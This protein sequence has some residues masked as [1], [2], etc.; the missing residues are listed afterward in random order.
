MLIPCAPYSD[1]VFLYLTK[2]SSPDICWPFV[3]MQR[4]YKI[5]DYI[6]Y[7]VLSSTWLI[8]FVTKS[9][10]FFISLTYFMIHQLPF[11]LATTSFFSAYMSILF[12]YIC[13]SIIIQHFSF[14]VWLISLCLIPCRYTH[15]TNGKIS[16]FLWLSN[17]IYK[18]YTHVHIWYI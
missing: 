18:L 6:L 16:F 2:W 13:S 10:C 14:Y 17:F 1:S 12:Y 8:Y 9:L 3:N 4:Y 5:I 15:V 7:A 11:P